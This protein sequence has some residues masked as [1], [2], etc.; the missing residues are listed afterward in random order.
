MC[1]N[2]SWKPNYAFLDTIE[3][4]AS[5]WNVWA[6]GSN[7]WSRRV[8]RLVMNSFILSYLL[9]SNVHPTFRTSHNPA[10]TKQ[11]NNTLRMLFESHK[12]SNH[13]TGVLIHHEKPNYAFLDTVERLASKSN[14][15]PR[16]SN[17]WS[18][19]VETFDDG[20]N[21]WNCQNYA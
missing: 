1:T 9:T 3:R 21:A 2:P 14:V 18:M 6:W 7:I 16:G 12:T 11:A 8:E 13:K 20:Q 4:L 17:V 10:T 15:W 5:K 19:I